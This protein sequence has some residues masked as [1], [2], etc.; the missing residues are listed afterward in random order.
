MIPAA[1]AKGVQVL[2]TGDIDYHTG[3]DAELFP[4]LE[5]ETARIRQ[6]FVIY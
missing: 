4:T 1:L 2:V 5:V 3:I 6:P